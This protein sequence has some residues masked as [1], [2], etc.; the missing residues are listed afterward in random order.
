MKRPSNQYLAF[1]AYLAS[2][3]EGGIRSKAGRA[4]G[5]VA[6]GLG[7]SSA[8]LKQ[9]VATHAD[10]GH[11]ERE[12][13]PKCTYWIGITE[14]GR[15][16]LVAQGTKVGLTTAGG[17]D[18]SHPAGSG[19]ADARRL[20]ESISRLDQKIDA[21]KIELARIEA[22]QSR[23]RQ[24]VE[25]H[26]A[27]KGQPSLLISEDLVRFEES[28]RDAEQRMDQ[29]SNRLDELL[30]DAVELLAQARA[31]VEQLPKAPAGSSPNQANRLADALAELETANTTIA[32]LEQDLARAR[33]AAVIDRQPG[34]VQEKSQIE[35]LGDALSAEKAAHAATRIRL[36]TE[37][38][39]VELR[40]TDAL[41]GKLGDVRTLREDRDREKARADRLQ[42]RVDELDRNYARVQSDLDAETIRTRNLQRAL[43]SL[44]V[45]RDD[46]LLGKA[47]KR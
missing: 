9:M 38:D 23:L 44:R 29:L 19:E 40:L 45:E 42:R 47:K 33:A 20:T 10:T 31:A 32:R 8:A 39:L 21:P 12:T 14:A 43:G 27:N 13:G 36:E 37:I 1:L 5:E 26:L 6:A 22:D 15:A 7:V 25:A 24:E 16:F 46:L 4:T 2:L 41:G 34:I 17:S 11:F 18:A 35:R 3:P 28:W 30:A